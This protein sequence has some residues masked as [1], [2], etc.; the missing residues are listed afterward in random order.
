MTQNLKSLYII[1]SIVI[2]IIFNSCKSKIHISTDKSC[3]MI[4][5]TKNSFYHKEFF[6]FENKAIELKS[7]PNFNNDKNIS[8]YKIEVYNDSGML[9]FKSNNP[10]EYWIKDNI[11]PTNIK[12]GNYYYLLK[13]KRYNDSLVT[14]FNGKFRLIIIE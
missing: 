13:M 14:N 3:K 1:C 2:V 8:K 6:H 11:C 7:F 12:E 10:N 9:C 5:Y 4:V